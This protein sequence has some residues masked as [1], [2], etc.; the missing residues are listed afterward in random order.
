MTDRQECIIVSHTVLI[1]HTV[2]YASNVFPAQCVL[3]ELYSFCVSGLFRD[4][5]GVYLPR[6]TLFSVIYWIVCLL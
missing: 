4:G 2:H 1:L 3:F 6:Q 5:M